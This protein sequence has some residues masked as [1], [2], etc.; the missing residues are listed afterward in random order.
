M[1]ILVT[2]ATGRIGSAV[3]D[4]LVAERAPPCAP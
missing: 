4:H 1:T 2:G 3:V